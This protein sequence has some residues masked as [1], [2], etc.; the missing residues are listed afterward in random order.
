MAR[1]KLEI[2]DY[3]NGK[4]A[5]TVDVEYVARPHWNTVDAGMK[6]YDVNVDGVHV[7]YVEAATESTDRDYGRIRVPGKG[8]KAWSWRSIDGRTNAPGLYASTRAVA[9]AK[10]VNYSDAKKV[11]A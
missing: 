5:K 10:L 4:P 11:K 9:V 2:R 3:R 8:R 1:E 7:G 6:S